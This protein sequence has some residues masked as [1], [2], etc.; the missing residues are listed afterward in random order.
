MERTSECCCD[1]QIELYR[2]RLGGMADAEMTLQMMESINYDSRWWR[3]AL[4]GEGNTVGIVL[5][6]IAFGEATIGYIGVVP[7]HRGRNVASF[8]LSEAWSPMQ[9]QG[10]STLSA[11]AD[12]RN[13]AMHRVLTKSQFNRHPQK[14]EWRLKTGV[15]R[16]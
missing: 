13:V 12:E 5:P 4:S 14:Q 2:Q 3:V 15:A 8:L 6:V 1:S 7:E 16:S 11:E 10:H 9:R